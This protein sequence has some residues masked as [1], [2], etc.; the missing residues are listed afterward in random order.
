MNINH[1]LKKKTIGD[2]EKKVSKM[3]QVKSISNVKLNS[4][5]DIFLKKINKRHLSTNKLTQYKFKL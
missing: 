4:H 5:L 1:K 2:E 3:I